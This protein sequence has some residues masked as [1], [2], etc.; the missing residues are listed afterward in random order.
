MNVIYF[1][2]GK[3]SGP[4][5]RKISTLAEVGRARG[6]HIE[7]LDYR[8]MA[9]PQDRV[10][11]L[12]R[13]LTDHPGRVILVG[14]SMGGYVSILASAAIK[15]AGLF[16]MAPAVYLPGYAVQEPTPWAEKTAIVHGWQDE[17][18]PPENVT[19]FARRH[20]AELHMVNDDHVLKEQL[21]FITELF[22]WFLDQFEAAPS[23][24]EAGT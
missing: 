21:P 1:A 16:L 2:H 11:M 17:V 7:S 12:L 24:P 20:R 8:H 10:E 18:V 14:S 3:E 13:R 9:D 6:Y 23:T 22:G 19:R 5:G 15:P 4:K